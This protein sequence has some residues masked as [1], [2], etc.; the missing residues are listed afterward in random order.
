MD[1]IKRLEKQAV[2]VRK[3]VVTAIHK[4]GDGHPGPSLSIADLVTALYF[5]I[6]NI[7][8]ED[9]GWE[10]RDRFILSKGHG[11]PTLYAALVLKGYFSKEHIPTLRQINSKLQ[12]HPDMT[13][14]IGVD[15][16]TGPL[17]NGISFGIGT[18]LAARMNAKDYYTY[19]I[20]G[21][22]ELNEGVIWEGVMSA[23]HYKVDSLIVFVDNN[24]YQS[25]G[26]INQISG[27]YPI[28]DKFGSFGWHVQEIDGHNM[29]EILD[30]VEVAK[31]TKGVPSVVIART[32]KGK[33]IAMMENNNAW[34]KASPDKEQYKEIMEALGGE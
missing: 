25:G 2:E 29:K 19:V 21:D 14:T 27:I 28:A 24:D 33:G 3:Q 30:S 13:K 26:K 17:G 10:D 12:G 20:T 34:H 6:M 1:K 5:E 15:A 4:G 31:R 7:R 16:S 9:P 22:G 8:P 23:F 32:V 18:A 11:C